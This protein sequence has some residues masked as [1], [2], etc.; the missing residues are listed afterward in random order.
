MSLGL[1]FWFWRERESWYLGFEVG[2]KERSRLLSN[3]RV[4]TSECFS[5]ALKLWERKERCA[6][7]SQSRDLLLTCMVL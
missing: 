1:R 7:G 4:W 3:Q 2:G 5:R 6:R